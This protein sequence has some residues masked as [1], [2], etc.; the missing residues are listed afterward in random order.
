MDNMENKTKQKGI[1]YK[2]ATDTVIMVLAFQRELALERKCNLKRDKPGQSSAHS[3]E[4]FHA[5]LSMDI[6]LKDVTQV[7]LTC[8]RQLIYNEQIIL[9]WGASYNVSYM[10]QNEKNHVLRRG[11][12][13]GLAK[14]CLEMELKYKLENFGWFKWKGYSNNVIKYFWQATDSNRGTMMAS[15]IKEFTNTF[16]H[17]NVS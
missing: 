7:R 11:R 2:K 9:P 13:Q 15:H 8:C 6:P 1:K 16:W 3:S 14:A 10:L 12:N 4:S 17:F 5:I